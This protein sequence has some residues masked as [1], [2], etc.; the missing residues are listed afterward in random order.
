MTVKEFRGWT[1]FAILALFFV[2]G[3]GSYRGSLFEPTL[4]EAREHPAFIPI[5][6][7]TLHEE[8]IDW[9]KIWKNRESYFQEDIRKI[10]FDVGNKYEKP[11]AGLVGTGNSFYEIII[12]LPDNQQKQ[13]WQRFLQKRNELLSEPG[14]IYPDGYFK[15]IEKLNKKYKPF[16]AQS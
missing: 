16:L 6:D 1:I 4:E 12:Y 13:L 5:Y 7:L 14:V 3:L 8:I 9:V 15:V 10:K 11:Y 2:L